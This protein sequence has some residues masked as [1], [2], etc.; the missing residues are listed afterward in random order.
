VEELIKA[1]RHVGRH[2]LRDATI[3]LLMFRHGLRS[4]EL[5]AL[6]WSSVDLLDGYLAIHRVKQGR[7]SV[8]PLR[9]PELRALRQLQLKYRDTQYVF[10]SERLAPLSTRSVRQIISRAGLLAGLPFPIHSHQLRHACGYYLAAQGHDT[11][12]IQDYL[13]H[14]NIQHTVR[15]TQ[16]NPS[17]FETFWT[18]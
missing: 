2:G 13:G 16:L 9:S 3:I 8:H 5:V 11:R 14:R 10:V 7:D 12:A 17:R 6:K 18:D 15:Y 4:A 1:A